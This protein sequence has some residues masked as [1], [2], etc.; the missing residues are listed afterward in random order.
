MSIL[1]WTLQALLALHTAIGAGWKLFNTE[2]SIP[3]LRAIP[4]GVWRA[5]I[6]LELICAAGLVAPAIA[7]SLGFLVPLAAIGI[8][9]EMLA[10]SVVHARS[11]A[12]KKDPVFYWLVVAAICAVIAAG[13][14]FVAPL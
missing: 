10:F 1:L 2:Q 7:P 13:R 4:S 12:G 14:L 5:L 11:G 6:P 9:A 3:G 8:A